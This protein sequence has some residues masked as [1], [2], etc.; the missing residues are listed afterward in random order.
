MLTGP[1]DVAGTADRL[2]ATYQ[3]L[4]ADVVPGSRLPVD[5]GNT[6]FAG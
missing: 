4:P 2:S 6:P 5:G 3:A 1:D